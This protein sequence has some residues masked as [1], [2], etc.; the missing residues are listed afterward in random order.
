MITTWT[1]AFLITR[2]GLTELHKA[3]EWSG[4]D[5]TKTGRLL[6]KYALWTKQ[7]KQPPL[8]QSV[9][10]V[11]G[12]EER[13]GTPKQGHRRDHWSH[14]PQAM[15]EEL[16]VGEDEAGAASTLAQIKHLGLIS[17]CRSPTACWLAKMASSFSGSSCLSRREGGPGAACQSRGPSVTYICRIWLYLNELLLFLWMNGLFPFPAQKVEHYHAN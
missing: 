5:G 10:N 6:G 14:G 12:E 15:W 11:V 2:P 9:I 13:D 4:A 3:Q 8:L 1:H 16:C 17:G 7:L